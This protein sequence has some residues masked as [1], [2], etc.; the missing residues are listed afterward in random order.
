MKKRQSRTAV[1]EKDL[2]EAGAKAVDTVSELAEQAWALAREAGHAASPRIQHSAESLARALERAADS[3]LA[4]AGEQQ[5]AEVALL[6]RERLADASEKLA[7]VVRPKAKKTHRIRNTAIALAAI[8]GVAALVQSPLRA[9]LTERLFGP[10][11]EDEPESITLPGAEAG[12]RGDSAGA[13][14]PPPSSVEQ[15][16]GVP[17]TT[18]AG[19]DAAPG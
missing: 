12:S 8:G 6:A 2:T 5:A 9:K 13:P 14:P 15:G 11:P 18:G 7:D 4:R 16:N 19:I 17:S 3:K 10:P 1:L